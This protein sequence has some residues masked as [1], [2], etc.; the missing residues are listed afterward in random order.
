[1]RERREVREVWDCGREGE[2]GGRREYGYTTLPL[3]S[4]CYLPHLPLSNPSNN[5][6]L[7]LPP[8]LASLPHFLPSLSMGR[9]G[10]WDEGRFGEEGREGEEGSSKERGG[11]EGE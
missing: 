9:M 7:P 10:L 1:M 4:P 6:I 8:S 2:E 11:R 3:L 5:L